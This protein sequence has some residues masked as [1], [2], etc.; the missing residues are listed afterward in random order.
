MVDAAHQALSLASSFGPRALGLGHGT[1]G[2]LR[3]APLD[4]Y[5]YIYIYISRTPKAGHRQPV[6]FSGSWQSIAAS[7]RSV[8]VRIHERMKFDSSYDHLKF[9]DVHETINVVLA[10]LFNAV[11]TM[12]S[13]HGQ[14]VQCSRSKKWICSTFLG[15]LV[16]FSRRK[17]GISIAKK[18]C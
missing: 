14:F 11:D 18:G 10:V 9:T 6:P 15:Q 4:I 5:I 17:E 13:Y 16:Q 2:G 12:A 1:V 3:A 7:P 8:V